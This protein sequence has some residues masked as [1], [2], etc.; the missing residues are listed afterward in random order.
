MGR[1]HG[2]LPGR[3][4]TEFPQSIFGRFRLHR[5]ALQG[6]PDMTQRIPRPPTK[7]LEIETPITVDNP[8]DPQAEQQAKH[9]KMERM[10]DRAARRGTETE[11]R[12]DAEHSTVSGS[13]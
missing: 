11:K 1:G 13:N 9:K 8:N 4:R 6:N 7:R 10:A 2:R 5:S 3:T 12:Y